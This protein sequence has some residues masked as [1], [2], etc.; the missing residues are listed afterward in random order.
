MSSAHFLRRGTRRFAVNETAGPS[1]DPRV[2]DWVARVVANGGATPSINTQQALSIFSQSLTANNLSGQMFVVNCM[3]PDSL[4]AAQTPL[5]VRMGYDIWVNHSFVS[6]DLTINGLIGD[7]ATKYMDTGILP[8]TMFPS[9]TSIGCS[10]YESTV[11]GANSGANFGAAVASSTLDITF[12][13]HFAGGTVLFDSWNNSTSRLSSSFSGAAGFVTVNRIA[14]NDVRAYFG[15]SSTSFG[16][17]GSTST[18]SGGTRTNV[19]VNI[20]AYA[21]NNAGAPNFF[22]DRRVS[23]LAIHSGLSASDAGNLFTAVQAVRKALGG[24]FA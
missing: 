18:G 16:Q 7:G 5:I 4:I 10:A 6:G 2:I 1:T 20:F 8:S 12:W 21:M 14:S 13:S 9:D 3:V 19:N 23:F 17:I 22:N 11:D 24:G 15:N